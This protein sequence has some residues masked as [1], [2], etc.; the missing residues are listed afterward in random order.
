MSFNL[1]LR[2]TVSLFV[3]FLILSPPAN[4]TGD[5]KSYKKKSSSVKSFEISFSDNQY[6]F[7][8][9]N[10]STLNTEQFIAS[11]Y[12]ITQ[13]TISFGNQVFFTDEALSYNDF[14]YPYQL[15]SDIKISS[16]KDNFEIVFYSDKKLSSKARRGHK[17]NLVTLSS[18]IKVD[19]GKF[20][21]G[22]VFSVA[23]NISVDGEVNKNIISLLGSIDLSSTAVARGDIATLNSLINIDKESTIYGEIY[24]GLKQK[25]TSIK[26]Y[27]LKGKNYSLSFNF[28][29]NRVDGANPNL[30]LKYR[31]PGLS[32]PSLEIKV[33]YAFESEQER[34][35][36]KS[37]FPLI[38]DDKLIIGAE[39]YRR[40]ISE[41][42][43]LLSDNENIVYTLFATEDY[44]DYLEADGGQIY[45]KLIFSRNLKAKIKY[46]SFDETYLPAQ[47]HLWSMFGGSKL[48]R[49]N[50]Y[51]SST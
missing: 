42:D 34:Y 20:F 36:I 17:G 26:R 24:S 18:A 33:G 16:R 39:M 5:Y 14:L 6:T 35:N 23:G 32:L 30:T 10:D 40:L 38:K 37:E 19:S 3:V 46:E 13:D 49:P 50:K 11:D 8:F 4:S 29:Y 48:F 7:K 45:L 27:S 28:K 1:F 44:K 9:Q 2:R 47:P 41:D 15:F 51:F 31:K 25:S 21:R 43:W 22:F 12:K